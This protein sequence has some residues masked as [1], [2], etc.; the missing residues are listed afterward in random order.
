MEGDG[1]AIAQIYNH[2]IEKTV[3]TFEES[4]VSGDEMASRIRQISESLPWLV[5][6]E[7]DQILGYAYGGKWHSRDAYRYS[8]EST[9]YLDS[10]SGGKGYGSL[11]YQRLLNDLKDRQYHIVIGGVALPNP[12]SVALH[13]KFGFKKVAH[14]EEVGF[15]FGQWIDVAYWQLTL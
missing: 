12:A 14:Y 4:L 3:V 1:E 13:E 5:I 8:A 10:K 2:Y 7:N 6:E 9:V 11:L 15:K